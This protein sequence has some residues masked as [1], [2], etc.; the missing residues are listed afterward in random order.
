MTKLSDR[1]LVKKA[2]N[3]D[4]EAFEELVT[5]YETRVYN[6]AYKM[7]GSQ[8]DAEDILQDTFLSAFKSIAGFKEKSSF[9]TW[10]YRIAT[11]ACLMKL[12]TKQS[13]TVSLD[14]KSSIITKGIVDW[15]GNA[16]ISLDRKELREVI[17][18]AVKLLPEM[19][20]AVFVLR[21]V[22]GLSNSEAA[23]VLNLTI[24][25]VKSRLHR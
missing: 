9:S 17:N 7:L 3:H 11:N 12:R 23:K 1:V 16:E 14:N 8:E 20:R 21:D 18:Q 13:R 25:A 2:K 19:Y 10:I 22:E 24:A 4:F 6:L 15:S 5:R